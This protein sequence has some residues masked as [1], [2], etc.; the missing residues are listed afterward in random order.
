MANISDYLEE[1]LLNHVFRTSSFTK[2]GTVTVALATANIT[3]TNTGATMTEVANSNAYARVDLGA[4]ADADWS[5]PSAGTQ[6][7]IDNAADITFPTASGGNWGTIL[8]V[9]LLDNT[10][11]GAGNI[12]F[13]GTL[14]TSKIVNDGDTFKF[15]TGDLNISLD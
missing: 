10:T 9:A 5:D 3:D 4:P 1:A 14:T 13:Y 7:L 12:L 6:G 2:P 8:D 11:H 15:S